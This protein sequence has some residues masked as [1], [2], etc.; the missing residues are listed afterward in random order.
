MGWYAC[1]EEGVEHSISFG[2]QGWP[3]KQVIDIPLTSLDSNKT[4]QVWVHVRQSEAYPYYNFYFLPKIIDPKGKR[5]QRTLAEAIFYDPKTGKPR[6]ASGSSIKTHRYLIFDRLRF[7]EAGTYRLSL[8][9]YM[10]EDTL[11]GIVS[12]GVSLK[13]QP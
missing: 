1:Q 12:I 10:R 2:D 4:Y 3:S 5:F 9:Q 11:K 6:A 8:T 7:K 13:P